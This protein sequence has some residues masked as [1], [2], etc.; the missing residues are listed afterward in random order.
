LACVLLRAASKAVQANAVDNLQEAT[1]IPPMS[2]GSFVE[3]L[4]QCVLP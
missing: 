2:V 1:M 3:T 4:D